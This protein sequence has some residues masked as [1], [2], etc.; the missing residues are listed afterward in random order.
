M[1]P[2]GELPDRLQELDGAK[3]IVTMCHY[4]VRS[5]RALHTLKAAGFERVRSLKGGI[6]AWAAEVA[7]EMPRY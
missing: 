1:I 5:L 7:P 6:E 3:D 4:G 2:L